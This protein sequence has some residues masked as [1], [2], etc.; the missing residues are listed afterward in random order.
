VAVPRLD[1]A[2]DDKWLPQGE[3]EVRELEVHGG[4]NP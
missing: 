2:G 3:V 1:I 4:S